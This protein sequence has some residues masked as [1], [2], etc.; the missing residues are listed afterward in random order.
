LAQ[1]KTSISI[2]AISGKV[3]GNIFSSGKGVKT[4]RSGR[5]SISSNSSFATARRQLLSKL[6]KLWRTLSAVILGPQVLINANFLNIPFFWTLLR[7]QKKTNGGFLQ[8]DT[9]PAQASSAIYQYFDTIEN[10]EYI[11]TFGFLGSQSANLTD[12]YIWIYDNIQGSTIKSLHMPKLN[13]DIFSYFSFVA[14]SNDTRIF[15]FGTGIN[16]I[17]SWQYCHI[18]AKYNV[19]QNCWNACAQNFPYSDRFGDQKL[20]SG[21]GLFVKLNLNLLALGLDP[22]TTTPVK[23]DLVPLLISTTGVTPERL[24]IMLSESVMPDHIAYIVYCSRSM[25]NSVTHVKTQDLKMLNPIPGFNNG[26]IDCF[27]SYTSLFGS[28][29]LVSN[30]ILFIQLCQFDIRSGERISQI[31]YSQLIS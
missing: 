19:S 14:T 24:N 28:G 21:N 26:T 12:A 22:V 13:I 2:A 31:K 5:K 23:S 16:S 27:D 8:L 30:S 11:V 9:L 15:I 17:H 4:L 3:G 20:L 6:Q 7:C 29:S 10:L 18:N 1:I 25:P